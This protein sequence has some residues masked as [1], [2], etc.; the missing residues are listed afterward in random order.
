[1]DQLKQRSLDLMK[2]WCDALLC[3]QVENN[4]EYLDGALLCPACHVVHG[5]IADLCYPLTTLYIYTG[6]K[7]YLEVADQTHRLDRIQ[8]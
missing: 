4:S 2:K 3:Y 8:S 7:H 1:M 5:R 6:D